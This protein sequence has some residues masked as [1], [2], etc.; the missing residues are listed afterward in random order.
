M[1]SLTIVDDQPK[2]VV[3]LPTPDPLT[4]HLSRIDGN[5]LALEKA[6]MEL[7]AKPPKQRHRTGRAARFDPDDARATPWLV[8]TTVLFALAATAAA[9]SGQI[10]MAPYTQMP[11]Y[12][13]FLVPLFIDLPVA[14]LG[15]MAQVFRRR[16]QSAKLTWGALIFFTAV[17]SVV[18]VV[19]VF[20]A[21][22][23]IAGR[24]LSVEDA[25]GASIMGLAPWIV[26]FSWEQL[27]RLLVRPTGEKREI[28]PTAPAPRRAT[29]T[30]R[31]PK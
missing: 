20:S 8:G 9:F 17:S 27:T 29:P 1:T 13:Y 25:V 23:I 11:A 26:L 28:E 3:E 14:L 16:K 22:D 5:F 30:K 10:A 15:Y 6:I 19:H 4:P 31:S 7:R 24:P 2:P 18:N 12:L 21:A